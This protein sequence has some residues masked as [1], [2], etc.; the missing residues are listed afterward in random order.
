MTT[1]FFCNA[2]KLILEFCT[3][4]ETP[5]VVRFK[6][7]LIA[8]LSHLTKL[9]LAIYC[10]LLMLQQDAYQI[11]DRSPISAV[12][13]KVK[14]SPNCSHYLNYS[15]PE[16]RYDAVDFVIPSLENSATSITTRTTETEYV[17]HLCNK[18]DFTHQYTCSVKQ[19]CLMPPYYRQLL[20]KTNQT[21]PSL[22]WHQFSPS[23][24]NNYEALDYTLFIKNYVEFP[25][26]HLVRK[27][28]V[29]D[30]MRPSYFTSCEYD[31]KH[32]RLCPKFRI[33]KILKLIESK[34]DEYEQMFHYGSLIEIKIIWKCNLDLSIKKCI[35]KYEFFRLDMPY[36]ENIFIP[37]NYFETSR[38]FYTDEH[39]LRRIT[40]KVYSLRILVTVAG[41]V[42]RFDMFQTTTSVGSFLGIFGMGAII[43]DIV[44]AYI[45]NFNIVKYDAK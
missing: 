16:S 26:L 24:K 4:Y 29:T 41:E 42:G 5:K 25:Q 12:T 19:Q 35:P 10:I 27:N 33:R 15:C 18:T 43:C 8:F 11:F 9:L 36:S 38:H 30:T 31:E 34:S 1:T 7:T 14:D 20:E 39:E 2:P 37:G 44:A 28:L 13:V 21:P 45:T 40:T 22:C 17:L 6:S 23:T 3:H 32:H